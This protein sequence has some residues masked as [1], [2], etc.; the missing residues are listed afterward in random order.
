MEMFLKLF[1]EGELFFV[2]HDQTLQFEL[3]LDELKPSGHGR[4]VIVTYLAMIKA[5]KISKI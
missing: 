4:D 2:L 3:F 5:E 1:Y